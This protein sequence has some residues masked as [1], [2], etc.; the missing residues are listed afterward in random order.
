MGQLVK[1]LDC[2]SLGHCRSE[3]SIP[4]GTQWV[5]GSGM[6][7]GVGQIQSLTQELPYATG[8]DKQG[9]PIMAQRKRI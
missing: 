4:S 1:N 9:V 8:A 5:K 6:A 2:S 7:A 3:G